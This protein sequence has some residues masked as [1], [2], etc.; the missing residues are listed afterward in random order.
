MGE[1]NSGTIT[2]NRDGYEAD[3]SMDRIAGHSRA[4]RAEK[5]REK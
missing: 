1:R 3:A 5:S 2:G 4:S